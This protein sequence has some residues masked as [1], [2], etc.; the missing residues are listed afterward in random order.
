MEPWIG[1]TR[2]GAE[3]AG[4]CRIGLN[5]GD[6]GSVALDVPTRGRSYEVLAEWPRRE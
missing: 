4:V 1:S 2:L 3:I 6:A 5:K